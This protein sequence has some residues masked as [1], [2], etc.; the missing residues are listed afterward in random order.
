MPA[1]DEIIRQSKSWDDFR[2]AASRLT[3]VLKGA[4]F[5]RLVQVFLQLDPKYSSILRHVWLLAEVPASI[6]E[7]LNLP[8]SDQG[9]DLLCKTKVGDYWAVQAKFRQNESG[10]V[11]WRE[12]ST[13]VGLA[14]GVCKGISFGLVCTNTDVVT[15]T[16]DKQDR[17][18]VCAGD[19]WRLLDSEFFDLAHNHLS[20]RPSTPKPFSPRPH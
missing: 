12:L 18:G 14:F 11:P 2:S 3:P 16:L 6:A 1:Y 8:S 9:I 20:D 4:A 7:S 19:V 15:K 5:E 13:F 17:I 10:S